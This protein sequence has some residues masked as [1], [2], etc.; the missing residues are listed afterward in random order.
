MLKRVGPNFQVIS[1]AEW[2]RYKRI[3]SEKSSFVV[4]ASSSEC[5]IRKHLLKRPDL[6]QSEMINALKSLIIERLYYQSY[7]VNQD[8]GINQETLIKMISSYRVAKYTKK[9]NYHLTDWLRPAKNFEGNV[10]T[11]A[12]KTLAEKSPKD[13]DKVICEMLDGI[14]LDFNLREAQGTPSEEDKLT[15]MS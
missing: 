1:D 11:R 5:P 8:A 6:G 3:G 12:I 15:R 13:A 7:A 14:P 2:K 9:S 4:K 10:I